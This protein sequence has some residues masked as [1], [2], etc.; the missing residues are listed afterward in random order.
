M[1]QGSPDCELGFEPELRLPGATK[2]DR[3]QRLRDRGL[4]GE[5]PSGLRKKGNGGAQPSLLSPHARE[6]ARAAFAKSWRQS[7][8]GR[9]FPGTHG[10]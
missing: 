8:E 3:L 10:Q 1:E 5:A 6:A 7:E 4:I 9:A 2:T